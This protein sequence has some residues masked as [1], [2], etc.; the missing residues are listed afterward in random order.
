[1]AAGRLVV[2]MGLLGLAPTKG[3][4]SCPAGGGPG[5]IDA[6][7]EEDLKCVKW[8]QTGGCNPDG[9]RE[10]H[11]DKSCSEE[12]PTGSS[13]YCQCG[14]VKKGTR[15]AREVTCDHRPFRCATECLQLRRYICVGWRQTGGCSA[16]GNREPH[17]DKPCDATIDATMSGFCECG[18]G[19]RI[20]KPGCQHGEFMEPFT[21]KAECAGEPNLYE[22]LNVDS[23][24]SEKDVKQAFRKLSLTLHP[25]K[26]RN[27]PVLTARFQ[28]VREAYDILSDQEQ[29]A[30]YDAAGLQMVFEA[31]NQKVEKGGSMNGE[32]HVTLEGMYNGEEITTNVQRKVICRGCTNQHT[33]RCQKCNQRCADEVEMR[34]VQMGPMVM[35]QQVQVPSKQKCRHS[36]TPLLVTVE[37][38]MAPGDTVV[39]KSMGE[40]QPKKIP[41]DVVLT[42]RERKHKVFRRV[43][44]D[45]NTE[46]EI[47]L[48]E[49]LL[50]WERSI[51]QLDG[52]TITFGVDGVTNPFA[53]LKIEGEGMPH[54]GDPTNRGNMIVKCKIKMPE[55]GRQFLRE[56]AIE[57]SGEL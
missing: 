39:F 36:K 40:Q 46:V 9:P 26:T 30:L 31:R 27:D 23:G 21:C 29:K 13:G 50:G 14:V 35:Q 18:D 5:C 49:A 7:T 32:V 52:R 38:G 53:L 45:L 2:A 6:I 48:R 12:V 41:G 47:S 37:R 15:R 24:A 17:Q 54:R 43:G 10:K 57:P 8:R 4:D 20:R 25:D 3:Q 19:R 44:V 22:E 28:A 51:T 34:N 1:M 55:D 33:A 56:N 11:G 16:D 42:L